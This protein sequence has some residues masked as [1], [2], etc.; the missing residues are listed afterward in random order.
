MVPST[1][2]GGLSSDGE[3]ENEHPEQD[4]TAPASDCYVTPGDTDG[5]V[6]VASLDGVSEYVTKGVNQLIKRTRSANMCKNSQSEV[7]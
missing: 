7:H 4:A 1:A 5:L 3:S 6:S 2:P